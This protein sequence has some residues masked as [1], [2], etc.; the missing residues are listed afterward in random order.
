MEPVHFQIIE[1]AAYSAGSTWCREFI[2]V[3]LEAIKED[4]TLDEAMTS[5]FEKGQL[6]V[7]EMRAN[8]IYP[9]FDDLDVP[10]I[11]ESAK[12]E[13]TLKQKT[14]L[15]VSA[16]NRIADFITFAVNP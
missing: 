5:L 13:L 7:N 4:T 16:A 8:Y 1:E 14:Q 3:V 12:K 10:G 11:S 2:K 6:D 15:L 9:L